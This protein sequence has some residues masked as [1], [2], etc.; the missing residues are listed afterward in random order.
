MCDFVSFYE[1]KE[2]CRASSTESLI[3]YTDKD[4]EVGRF[5]FLTDDM[6][7]NTKR[8]KELLDYDK[9]PNQ[10]CMANG[11]NAIAFYYELTGGGIT[12]LSRREVYDF[13]NPEYF[14]PVIVTAIKEFKMM[15]MSF[16]DCNIRIKDLLK[17]EIGNKIEK[18]YRAFLDVQGRSHNYGKLNYTQYNITKESIFKVCVSKKEKEEI[19]A[20]LTEIISKRLAG[21]PGSFGGNNILQTF[22]WSHTKQGYYYWSRINNKKIIKAVRT[23]EGEEKGDVFHYH[24]KI[25]ELFKNPKNRNPLWL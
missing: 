9:G 22:S 25:W 11:H 21:F 1:L 15:R 2:M 19:F 23:Y 8:G 10:E 24:K 7:W 4:N 6:V 3:K 14:P 16:G 12:N 5:L 17:P 20:N 13:S 18:K